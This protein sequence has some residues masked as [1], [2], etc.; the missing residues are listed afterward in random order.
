MDGHHNCHKKEKLGIC[1]ERVN[2]AE[3]QQNELVV[4]TD[5]GILPPTYRVRRSN[6]CRDWCGEVFP[7]VDLEE[8]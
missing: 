1:E 7:N 5:V 2:S 4:M 3:T 8:Q 6:E